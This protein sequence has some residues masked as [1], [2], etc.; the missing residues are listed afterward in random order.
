MGQLSLRTFDILP[1][2]VYGYIKAELLICRLI[3][4]SSV[5]SW[6]IMAYEIVF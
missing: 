2:C 3:L 4:A 6:F 1:D 5:Y